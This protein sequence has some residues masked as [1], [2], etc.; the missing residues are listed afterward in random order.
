MSDLVPVLAGKSQNRYRYQT[1]ISKQKQKKTEKGDF[2]KVVYKYAL[3][4]NFGTWKKRTLLD[5]TLF[6]WDK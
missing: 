6:Q 3:K 2:T 4:F 1:P 5:E